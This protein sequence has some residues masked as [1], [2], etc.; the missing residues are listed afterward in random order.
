MENKID[1]KRLPNRET[2]N[3]FGCSPVNPSGL[4]MKFY[5]RDS[6]VFSRLTV[7]EHLCGW[8]RLVH[9]GVIST[10]LDEIMSWTGI[11]ML[12][13]IT[14]TKSMTVEFIKPVYINSELK[15]EGQV[16]EKTGKH[17]A[18]LEGRL[19]NQEGT[20]CARSRATFVIFSP[21]VAKRL[22]IARKEHLEWFEEIYNF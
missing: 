19:Y 3:C 11:Y 8:D 9:G 18:L 13:Q 14:M 1:P 22:G 2:H 5:T 15:A 4:Q 21:K 16:L 20:L 10:I 6:S 7:P 12:K 17:E